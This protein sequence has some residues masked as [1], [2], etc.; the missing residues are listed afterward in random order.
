MEPSFPMPSA[1]CILIF[2]RI[3]WHLDSCSYFIE[4]M[5]IEGREWQDFAL[6]ARDIRMKIISPMQFLTDQLA[7]V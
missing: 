1:I 7:L 3:E 4:F 6:H 5:G 2:E